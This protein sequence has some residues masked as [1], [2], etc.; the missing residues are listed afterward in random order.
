MLIP[1]NM[2][3]KRLLRLM[4]KII[5]IWVLVLS[6]ITTTGLSAANIPHLLKYDINRVL[7]S[8]K[9]G[10][11]YI[12]FVNVGHALEL[13]A[14]KDAVCSV[15]ADSHVRVG[16]AE[17][18]QLG[19]LDP[20]K[21]EQKGN[22]RF[23]QNAKILIYVVNDPK[24]PSF[25]SV[26]GK[27][28]IVNINGFDDNLLPSRQPEIYARR[29]R[30]LMLKGFGLAIGLG[31]TDDKRCAL[32]YKSFTPHGIDETSLGFSFSANSTMMNLLLDR[33]GETI[34]DSDEKSPA[35]K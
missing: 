7:S 16:V 15:W 11:P 18:D 29:M 2:A 25:L 14:M 8:S 22:K 31:Y 23:D 27:W 26:A 1:D 21:K 28:S 13:N 9:K 32:Y 33:F 6:V 10:K 3:Q 5:T 20:F 19:P 17:T 4:K 12:L 30:Q 24:I 34:F 35:I